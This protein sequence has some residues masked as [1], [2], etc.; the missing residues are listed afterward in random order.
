MV[1]PRGM[2]TANPPFWV[3]D[4]AH[5]FKSIVQIYVNKWSI[6]QTFVNKWNNAQPTCSSVQEFTRARQSQWNELLQTLRG[7]I[8]KKNGDCLSSG[9]FQILENRQID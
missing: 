8:L 4:Y 2:I 7:K 6:A 5:E 3:V 1:T 9:T